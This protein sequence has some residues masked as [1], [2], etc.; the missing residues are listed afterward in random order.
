MT[1]YEMKDYSMALSYYEKILHDH[2]Q[3]H[4]EVSSS[5]ATVNNN[6]G[7]A[8]NLMEDHS[9]ALLYHKTAFDIIEKILPSS[10]SEVGIVYNNI[11]LDYYYMED[12][13]TSI[14]YYKKKH[15]KF[16]KNHFHLLIQ[17]LLKLMQILVEPI[18]I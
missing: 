13:S 5:V 14:K 17:N 4:F 7:L 6:M 8:Y 11:G 15:L 1:Y 3:S 9:K 12:Y 18:M 16:M 10:H 2:K